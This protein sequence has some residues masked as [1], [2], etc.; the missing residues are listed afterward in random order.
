MYAK[1]SFATGT[2]TGEAVR[3]I[4][5]LITDSNGGSASLDNLEFINTGSSSLTA[6]TN[7]GWSLHEDSNSIP[8]DGTAVSSTDSHFILEG[9]CKD[10]ST[11]KKYCSVLV[12]GS[13]TSSTVH[14]G[15]TFALTLANVL[16][17]GDST[18]MFSNGYSA[19]TA[20]RGDCHGVMPT[21]IHVWADPRRIILHGQDGN[22]K[23]T[24]ITHMEAAETPSTEAFTLPPVAVFFTTQS[25]YN[26]TT[27]TTESISYRGDGNAL[28]DDQT[29][30]IDFISFT[31]SMY[32]HKEGNEGVVRSVGWHRV[33]G[34]TTSYDDSNG[35]GMSWCNRQDARKDDG[36]QY[37]T[38][39]TPTT[40]TQDD[41]QKGVDFLIPNGFLWWSPLN[42][43]R[44]WD[45]SADYDST[46]GRSDAQ[47][48][49]SS[50]TS[51]IPMFPLVWFNSVIF[52]T[53]V[54][55]FGSVSGINRAPA[56]LGSTGD[57]V[58]IGSDVYQYISM[59][60]GPL[61]AFLVKRT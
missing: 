22:G 52:N 9:S 25:G 8:S 17:P 14:S 21:T 59:G 58:S 38:L 10:D 46:F 48:F 5:T 41:G 50:G 6:G 2:K 47:A 60:T 56:G 30:S 3:D 15:T 29:S 35:A 18:E 31:G 43:H 36:T 13:F 55:D 26:L 40:P 54:Y 33:G 27:N 44:N 12:N 37:G 39:F 28:W 57:T 34:P 53:E 19:T 1:L 42:C 11:K 20:S 23:K 16:D 24:L 32:M 51:G 61:E 45:D 4:V 49:N 7:S